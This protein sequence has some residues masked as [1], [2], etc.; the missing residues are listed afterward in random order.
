[1]DRVGACSSSRWARSGSPD[2][3]STKMPSSI[4]GSSVSGLALTISNA[5]LDRLVT[6][7]TEMVVVLTSSPAIVVSFCIFGFDCARALLAYPAPRTT[8]AAFNNSR[9]RI[10]EDLALISVLKEPQSLLGKHLVI[11]EDGAVSSV[12][13]NAELS[14]GQVAGQFYGID[15]R[16]HAFFIAVIHQNQLPDGDNTSAM[17]HTPFT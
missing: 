12:R 10:A 14:I 17:P 16:H 7:P 15:C 6:C 1:M 9:L 13:E 8:A 3:S 2:R 5:L 4:R 11:L